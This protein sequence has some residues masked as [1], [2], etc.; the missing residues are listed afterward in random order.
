MQLAPLS[1]AQNLGP[2]IFCFSKR[3]KNPQ[4]EQLLAMMIPQPDFNSA[5]PKG[6]AGRPLTVR[7]FSEAAETSPRRIRRLIRQGRLSTTENQAGEVR[8]PEGELER[9]L[10]WKERR[11]L[12]R[13]MEM[14]AVS[15]EMDAV[16]TQRDDAVRETYAMQVPLPRHE[17]A[18]MRLGYLEAELSNTKQL[19]QATVSK[20]EES[21]LRAEKL[22]QE[23]ASLKKR[24]ED[25]ENRL[26]EMRVQT[27][28]S[29][30]RAIELQDELK[31][32]KVRLNSSWWSRFLEAL[33]ASNSP[34]Q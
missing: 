34:P 24:N 32:L 11:V 33:R 27:I 3:L 10:A 17:A 1:F 14:T 4:D 29:T 21:R 18:M 16:S 20:E 30:F 23:F 15:V 6:D 28:D 7:A 26:E 5:R 25:T 8:I 19:L 31:K 12:S 13:S 9:I 22:D 2:W